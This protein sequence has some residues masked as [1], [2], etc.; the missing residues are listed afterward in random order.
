MEFPRSNRAANRIPLILAIATMLVSA[1]CMVHRADPGGTADSSVITED[2]I[3]SSHAYTAFEAVYRLRPRF[4]ASRGKISLDPSQPNALPNVYVDNQF[5]GD[6]TTL[7]GIA[8][9]SIESIKFYTPGEAQ[10]K[11]GHGNMA[12]VIGIF[13]KH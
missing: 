1:A 6:I 8:A 9:G 5:Y 2:E 4:L 10:Y 13:T 3:D 12:G 7:R 11:F